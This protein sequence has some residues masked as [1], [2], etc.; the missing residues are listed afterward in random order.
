MEKK[1]P[2]TVENEL[3]AHLAAANMSKEQLSE[4]SRSIAGTRGS[5]LRIVDWWI[6]GIPAFERIIIQAHLPLKEAEVVGRLLQNER[7]KGVDIWRK[8]IPKPDFF[9]INLTIENVRS[10]MPQV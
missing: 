2:A 1:A 8:G 7:F 10:K 5:G 4:I 9:Q 3:M 6:L